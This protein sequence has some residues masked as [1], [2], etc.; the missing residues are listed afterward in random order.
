M[1]SQVWS[2]AQLQDLRAML[3]EAMLAGASIDDLMAAIDNRLPALDEPVQK[4]RAIAKAPMLCPSCRQGQLYRCPQ[5]GAMVCSR[6]C[7]FSRMEA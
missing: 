5:T 7:G 6:H 2:I 1:I 3:S 4:P